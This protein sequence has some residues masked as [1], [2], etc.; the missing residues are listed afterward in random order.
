MFSG[1]GATRANQECCYDK[2]GYLSSGLYG[3]HQLR[4]VPNSFFKLITWLDYFNDN[5]APY[6]GCCI[7]SN[8]PV[9]CNKYYM[10]RPS[11]NCNGFSPAT[12]SKKDYNENTITIISLTRFCL[13]RASSGYTRWSPIYIQW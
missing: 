9:D 2:N 11:S 4:N 5:I 6:I 3:G 12:I 7:T 10:N 8:N 1:S 13:W